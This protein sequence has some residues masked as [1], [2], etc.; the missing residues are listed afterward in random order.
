M[1]IAAAVAAVLGLIGFGLDASAQPA[2]SSSPAAAATVKV[3]VRPVTS[4]G[5]HAAGFQVTRESERVDCSYTSP[6]PG[7][8]DRYI[9]FCS[10]SVAY[11]IACWKA[12]VAHHV[13]CMRNP[14]SHELYRMPRSGR[15]AKSPLAPTKDRAPLRMVLG[16]GSVCTI[17]DGGAWGSLKNH[18]QWQGTYSCTGGDNVW[19]P[20]HAHHDGV[21]EQNPSW[22]VHTASAYGTGPI[23]V[24]HVRKAYFVGT[25]H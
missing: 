19:A 25:K 3:V 6:S 5:V 21:N 4:A 14:A 10:P 20:P 13:L 2:S 23:T 11:A 7:A 22:T 18:P 8:V 24:R 16:N 9:D 12:R 15:F 17:R 1:R